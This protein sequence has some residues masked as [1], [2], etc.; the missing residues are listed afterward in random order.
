MPMGVAVAEAE[1][2]GRD[3]RRQR[4][5]SPCPELARGKSRLS[6]GRS[7]LDSADMTP[8]RRMTTMTPHP[9]R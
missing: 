7:S 8:E 9:G 4:P 6:T 3:V 1:E 5:A 2:V